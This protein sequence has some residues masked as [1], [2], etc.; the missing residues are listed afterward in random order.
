MRAARSTSLSVHAFSRF[1]RNGAEMELTIRKLR[2]H[3]VEVVSVTQPTGDDPTQDMMRQMIGIFDEYT[4]RENGKNVTRAMRELAKQ[5][6][7]NGATPPLG[8]RIVEAE[9]R[10]QKIKKKLDIDPVEAE[11]VRLIFR[12]YLEGDGSSGPLGIKEVTKWLNSRGHRTRR[13]STF[14]VG[15]VHNILR[16][17]CYATGKWPYGR[18]SSRTGSKHDPAT[19]IE[20]PIPT[21]STPPTSV[22]RQQSWSTTTRARHLRAL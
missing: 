3:G 22:A 5:G 9:R 4:S 18:R 16:N 21:L 13:G 14:G 19:I 11:L 15:P 17:A 8:Y 2:K 10:G 20:I 1:Y 7:W 6:F 12:L